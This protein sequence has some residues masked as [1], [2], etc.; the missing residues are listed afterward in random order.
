MIAS[1][2]LF[3]IFSVLAYT[4]ISFFAQITGGGSATLLQAALSAVRPLPILIL[5]VGNIFFSMAVFSGFGW[6]KFAVPAAIALGV[7]T[8]FVYSAVFL[9]GAVSLVRMLGVVFILAGIYFL[10]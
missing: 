7:V 6:T 3:A 8:S 5:I 9:G 2:G 10:R 4:C 1:V